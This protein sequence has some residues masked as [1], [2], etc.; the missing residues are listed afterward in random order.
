MSSVA[1]FEARRKA[2]LEELGQIF[3]EHYDLTYRTAYG[4]TRN[5]EDAEVGV[6]AIFLELLRRETQPALTR[7][8]SG[9]FYRYAVNL[10]LKSVR[11]KQHYVLTNTGEKFEGFTSIPHDIEKMEQYLWAAIA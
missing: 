5:V 1:V 7:N 8:P 4:I 3:E 2:L 9:Y 10:S 11:S 6:Q